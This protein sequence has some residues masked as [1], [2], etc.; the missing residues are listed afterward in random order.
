MLFFQF[1]R[2]Y[3]E[4]DFIATARE[5][6][7]GG[8]RLPFIY[9]TIPN[10]YISEPLKSAITR[11]TIDFD[12]IYHVNANGLTLPQALDLRL[13]LHNNRLIKIVLLTE[14][15]NTVSI[16][17]DHFNDDFHI[18]TSGELDAYGGQ[19]AN[20][21]MLIRKDYVPDAEK[22]YKSTT[23][24]PGATNTAFMANLEV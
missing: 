14:I 23:M 1:L 8:K 11:M 7:N 6:G 2:V 24:L 12:A 5:F 20:V 19:T 10:G 18:T 16:I 15:K 9:G 4:V 3:R 21:A 22:L 13:M 17:Q